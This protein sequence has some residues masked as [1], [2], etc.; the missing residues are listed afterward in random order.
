MANHPEPDWTTWSAPDSGPPDA[1]SS[2]SLQA[3]PNLE[4]RFSAYIGAG[5]NDW[6]GISPVTIDHIN[7][8]RAWPQIKALR[9]ATALLRLRRRSAWP[10]IRATWKNPQRF[11]AGPL[12]ERLDDI[13]RDGL[14]LQQ[15][16]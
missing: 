15:C 9:Q 11:L 3:P 4:S 8:E 13:V 6:G 14:A 1:G 16:V 12:A 7:P 10:S 2:I 5:I